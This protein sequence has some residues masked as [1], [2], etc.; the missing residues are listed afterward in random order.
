MLVWNH[1]KSWTKLQTSDK[2]KCEKIIFVSLILQRRRPLTFWVQQ[3]H[4]NY[5]FDPIT[6]SWS[7]MMIIETKKCVHCVSH[8]K[9]EHFHYGERCM[10][11]TFRKTGDFMWFSGS[12]THLCFCSQMEVK[13][14]KKCSGSRLLMKQI[15]WALKCK[16]S[17]KK[18]SHSVFLIAI[19]IHGFPFVSVLIKF[20]LLKS[21]VCLLEQHIQQPVIGALLHLTN[22]I[23]EAQIRI[24][25]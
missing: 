13:I 9:D 20:W 24:L 15:S 4:F 16:F 11:C 22:T 25:D 3:S 2:L 8:V 17:I 21:K 18:N 12:C 1:R 23:K 6:V 10:W 5:R 7:D 14:Q 19:N